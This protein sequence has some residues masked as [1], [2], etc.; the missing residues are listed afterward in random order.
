MR[1]VER[2]VLVPDEAIRNAQEMLWRLLRVVAEPGGAAAF[3]ALISGR[4]QP[5]PGER[6]GVMVRGGNTVAVDFAHA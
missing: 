2:V 5:R 1:D 4:Y 3:S 6:V